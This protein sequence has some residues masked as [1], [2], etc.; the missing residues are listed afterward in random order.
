MVP[1]RSP[2]HRSRTRARSWLDRRF[3]ALAALPGFL[4]LIAVTGVPLAAAVVFSFSYNKPGTFSFHWT[5]LANYRGDV[6]A[7]GVAIE[8]TMSSSA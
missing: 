8:N 2:D 7:L 6:K 5:G 4:V 3:F 1:R